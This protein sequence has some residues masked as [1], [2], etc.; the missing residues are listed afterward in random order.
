M[1]IGK[2]IGIQQEFQKST[3]ALIKNLTFVE[4]S[5]KALNKSFG[6]SSVTAKKYAD[7][8]RKFAKDLGV[9][10]IAIT[11]RFNFGYCRYD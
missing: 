9:G 4:E 3:L 10:C 2:V 7:T 6:V 1:G 11:K 8:L 5:N